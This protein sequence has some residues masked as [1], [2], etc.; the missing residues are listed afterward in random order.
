[1][2]VTFTHQVG[3]GLHSAI[4]RATKPADTTT[5]PQAARAQLP[6]VQPSGCC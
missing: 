6:V 4:I 3:D 1:V 5:V 2:S